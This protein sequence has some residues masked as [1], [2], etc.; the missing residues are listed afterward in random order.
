M[1]FV[2]IDVITLPN[3]APITTATARSIM[4]PLRAN[5]LNS[6]TRFLTMGFSDVPRRAGRGGRATASAL[7]AGQGRQGGK[8]TQTNRVKPTPSHRPASEYF[9]ARAG[10]A[11]QI[12]AS[13]VLRA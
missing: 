9:G 10:G 5:V 13:R 3:A 2:T 6:W 7:F 12:H 1:T 8:A 11:H 4:F